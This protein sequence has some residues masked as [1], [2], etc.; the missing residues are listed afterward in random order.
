MIHFLTAQ[1]RLGLIIILFEDLQLFVPPRRIQVRD[2][3]WT[4]HFKRT[5]LG[6]A[7]WD[8]GKRLRYLSPTAGG[9]CSLSLKQPCQGKL[10]QKEIKGKAKLWVRSAGT[11]WE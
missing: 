10:R 2:C 5:V 3:V 11:A 8:R 4:W 7:T 9:C 1:R 6:S